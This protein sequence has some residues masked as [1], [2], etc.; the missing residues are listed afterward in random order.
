MKSI[1]YLGALTCIALGGAASNLDAA[2]RKPQRSTTQSIDPEALSDALF[3][4]I[5][6]APKGY[7][8]LTA[9][10]DFLYW[11]ANL[12]DFAYIIS[13]D[14]GSS[15]D[16]QRT[17]E[18]IGGQFDPGFRLGLNYEMHCTGWDLDLNW[19]RLYS[20]HQ[21]STTNSG[22]TLFQY[23]ITPEDHESGTITSASGESGVYFNELDF[24]I[25]RSLRFSKW[26]QLRPFFGIRQLWLDL[27]QKIQLTNSS[28]QQTTVQLKND[29]SHF[30]LLAG[31]GT[32]FN[33][34]KGFGLYGDAGISAVYGSNQATYKSTEPFETNPQRADL[35]TDSN[36]E[37]TAIMDLGCGLFWRDAFFDDRVGFEASIGYE[38]HLLPNQY[39][40]Y[41]LA[42]VETGISNSF[43]KTEN[44]LSFHGL[45]LSF[46][47][48]F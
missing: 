35:S 33:F 34:G 4:P 3:A 6:R 7:T 43:F 5:Y 48:S 31:F 28:N 15:A 21:Q 9:Y 42:V 11:K 20:S 19:S 30:G 47:V 39:Y 1:Y 13:N 32:E 45:V 27:K 14:T 16:F 41:R 17:I 36:Q 2:E 10:G 8:H 37:M 22:K 12:S 38:M 40:N 46:G 26:M 23:W 18:Q 44:S 25:G 29:I 24:T